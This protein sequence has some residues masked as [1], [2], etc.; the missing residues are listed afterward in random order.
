MRQIYSPIRV[1]SMGGIVIHYR[2]A[3]KLTT[4]EDF[5]SEVV[6]VCLAINLLNWRVYVL[7][8]FKP[9]ALEVLGFHDIKW[10]GGFKVV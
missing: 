9:D 3:E 1:L 5:T 10:P 8:P 2:F 6:V 7:N 4:S